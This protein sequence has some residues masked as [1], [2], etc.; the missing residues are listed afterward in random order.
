MAQRSLDESDGNSL[1]IN[2]DTPLHRQ[3]VREWVKNGRIT[4]QGFKLARKD[5]N[6]LS[7]AQGE[8]VSPAESQQRHRNRGHRSDAVATITRA[9][10]R[11]AGLMPVH[12][13]SPTPEHVSTTFPPTASNSQKDIIA[14]RLA[15]K[16]NLS[17]RPVPK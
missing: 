7:L 9:E 13:A 4:S 3:L 12:D 11:Q 2:N 10:C 5:N 1:P 15:A 6:A 14:R 17:V 8:I 16:A